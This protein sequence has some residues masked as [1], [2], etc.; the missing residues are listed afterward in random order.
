MAEGTPHE[1]S[2]VS[3]YLM[4]DQGNEALEFYK[5]AF[6][7]EVIETYPWEGR[8]GHATLRINGGDVM[9]SGEFPEYYERT[10][11]KSPATLGGTTCTISLA[12]D[13]VDKWHAR[14][15]GAGAQTLR[16][17]TNE[18]YGRMSKVRDPFG[19]VW[20]FTGPTLGTPS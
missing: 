7:A 10:G 14:A 19:H 1:Y 8:L 17:P 2:P 3:P 5:Q 13:D 4:V 9:L 16:E 12:V 6:G 20:S 11:T 18:F 15:T